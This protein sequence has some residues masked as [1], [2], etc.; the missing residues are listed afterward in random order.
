MACPRYD[1]SQRSIRFVSEYYVRSYFDANYDAVVAMQRLYGGLGQ[2]YMETDRAFRSNGLSVIT[3]PFSQTKINPS[4]DTVTHIEVLN[5]RV[6][7]FD[8]KAV[9]EA[10]WH[11]MTRN[12]V[13][14]E[15]ERGQVQ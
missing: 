14:N 12:Y 15:V 13:E 1:I 11:E 3:S 5:C 6:I 8:Y 4:T 9:G 10:F 7:P 2:L